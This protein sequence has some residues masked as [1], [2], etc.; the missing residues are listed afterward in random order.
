MEQYYASVYKL[1][2][3]YISEIDDSQTM[4]SVQVRF[5]INAHFQHK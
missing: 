1:L 3:Y 5:Y 2:F 4:L